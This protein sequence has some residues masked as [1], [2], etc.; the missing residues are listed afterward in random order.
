MEEAP[1]QICTIY[2]MVSAL[3]N[4]V[5]LWP[6]QTAKF[7]FMVER[8]IM[9]PITCDS[10]LIGLMKQHVRLRVVT[11]VCNIVDEE[12]PATGS[13]PA[14]IGQGGLTRTQLAP[15]KQKSL[16]VRMFVLN[17]NFCFIYSVDIR[18][19]CNSLV[20]LTGSAAR[21]ET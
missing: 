18:Q 7:N 17:C 12:A 13:R 19:L 15:G 6:K 2:S 10:Q 11:L 3:R 21:L 1:A 5:E 16:G 14:I 8:G 9:V 20:S 4:H